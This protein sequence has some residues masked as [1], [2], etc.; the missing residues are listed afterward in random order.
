MLFPPAQAAESPAGRVT[1]QLHWKHQFEFAAFYAALEKGYY[2]D[3]GL[4]VTIREGGPGIDAVKEVAAGA[5]DFGISASALVV[6]RYRGLPV[7]ALAALMQH[8]PTAL[9]ASRRQGIENIQDLVGKTI[10]V[11]PHTRDETEA[12]LRAS[13][14]NPASV[15]LVDQTDWTLASLD[16]GREAAKVVYLSNEPFLIRGRQ[17]EFLLLT[18][19]SA[20][21]DLFGNTLFTVQSVIKARPDMVKAFRQA[22]LKGLVYALDHP[23]ELVALILERYN[24]QHKSREHLLFEAAQIRELTRTDIVEPGYMSAGR[25]RHVVDIYSGQGKLPAEF[26]LDGFIYDTTPSKTPTWLK[27]AL[28]ASLAALLA[29]LLFMAKIRAFNLRLKKEVSDRKQAE[30]ALTASEAKYRELI[31][32]ANALILRLAMDGKVNYLNDHAEAFFGYSTA[33]IVGRHVVGTI[34]P[35][36]ESGTDRDLAALID[37]ILADPSAHEFNENEN[38]TRAGRKVIV[39][40]GNRAILDKDGQRVGV[41]CIGQDITASHAL[42]K[43]RAT[44]R[45]QLEEKVSVRTAELAQAKEVAEAANQAKSAFLANMSH[46]IRTPMNAI[47][48]MAH[49]LRREGATLQQADRLDKIDTAAR[50]LLGIISDV[51]DISKIES[52]KFVLEEAPV[53]IRKL[54][55]D[56]MAML[57]ERASAKGLALRVESDPMPTNLTGDATRLQQAMLNYASNAIKFTEAGSVILRALRQDETADAMLL[58]F[59]VRDTGIGISPE[60]LPRLFSTF[61]QADNSTTRKYGGTGLGLSITRHLAEMMGGEAGAES[62]PGAGSTFWFTAWLKKRE[63][64]EVDRSGQVPPADAQQL[65]RQRHAGARVLVVDDEEM[66]L[67]I[68]RL[69]L[70]DAGLVV[71]TATDGEQALGMARQS[72]YAAVLMDMQMPKMDG[73]EAVRQMRKLAQCGNVPVIAMTANVFAEDKARCLEAGMN[74]FLTKPVHPATLFATLLRWLDH[75]GA[76]ARLPP[77]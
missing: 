34:V 66:N 11:D 44:H 69:H 12:Y 64:R 58:R 7:V 41:L 57:F 56:V 18:P 9:L 2:R 23:D 32:N 65:L 46:E 8:S 72:A 17:H 51:L 33:D 71:S 74:D 24:T 13:G 67:E 21:I 35:P 26:D 45:E 3:A 43:E 40:W 49:L 20:G 28:A 62:R 27:L 6:D 19:R 38:V 1:V 14:V 52:G 59:E 61:E 29:A 48:G 47:L 53:N 31:D 63:R 54:A 60:I 73:L 75:P 68:A 55:D 76:D 50:H 15:R 70:E 37:A 5:A 42:E 36:R 4:E 10:S 77:P 39:R 16:S 22:T 25:W 30:Q